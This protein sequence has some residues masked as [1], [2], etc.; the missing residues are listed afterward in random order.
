MSRNPISDKE[1]EALLHRAAGAIEIENYA[2]FVG[3]LS[4]RLIFLVEDC[5]VAA[6]QLYKRRTGED[7]VG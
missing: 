1:L 6:N 7:Y 2:H 5:D 4:E 3:N